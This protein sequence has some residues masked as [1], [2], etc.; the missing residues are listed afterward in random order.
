MESYAFLTYRGLKCSQLHWNTCLTIQQQRAY[1]KNLYDAIFPIPCSIKYRSKTSP[2]NTGLSSSLLVQLSMWIALKCNATDK[3]RQT[4]TLLLDYFP[5]TALVILMS[6]KCHFTR[7]LTSQERP[8]SK[9]HQTTIS[10][11]N[12]CSKKNIS[13]LQI[14]SLSYSRGPFIL[15]F[16]FKAECSTAAPCSLN[17][18]IKG[19]HPTNAD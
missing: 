16:L 19:R 3:T 14:W 11:L 2:E 13:N 4:I 12:H 10:I 5:D 6:Y 15:C 17:I 9:N 7:T 18:L 1:Y 8:R